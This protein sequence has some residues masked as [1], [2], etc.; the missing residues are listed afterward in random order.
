MNYHVRREQVP[1]RI[2]AVIRAQVR[3]QDLGRIVPAFCG[4]VWEYARAAK[5]SKPG[6]HVAVYLDGAITLEC[7]VEVDAAF[8]GSARVVCSKT[9]AG[10]VATTT[11][12]GGYHR[13]G[14]AHKA[15]LDWC[16]EQ[17]VRPAGPSW[18]VYGHWVEPPAEPRTDIYYLLAP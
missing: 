1:S 11:H 4:E 7:G 2:I 15:V 12:V 10:P 6:R 3:Q 18:E 8:G 5:L 14:E 16:T 9:P 13:L 17:G